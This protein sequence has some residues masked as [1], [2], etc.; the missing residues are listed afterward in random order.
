MLVNARFARCL[1]RNMFFM[2]VKD[3][4]HTKAFC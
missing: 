3:T 2:I 1:N 4:V